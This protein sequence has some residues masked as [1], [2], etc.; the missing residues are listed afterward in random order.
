MQINKSN[1]MRKFLSLIVILFTLILLHSCQKPI[2][3]EK[4]QIWIHYNGNAFDS[5]M[6]YIIGKKSNEKSTY[7]K[8]KNLSN[9]KDSTVKSFRFWRITEHKYSDTLD[10]VAPYLLKETEIVETDETI[11]IEEDI[12][13]IE[14]YPELSK[15]IDEYKYHNNV[16]DVSNKKLLIWISENY[17]LTKK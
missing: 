12:I 14:N 13:D 2:T 6:F 7:I 10:F 4:G 11:P 15:I 3:Y 17:Y 8:Y 16:L 5:T 9:G 1:N